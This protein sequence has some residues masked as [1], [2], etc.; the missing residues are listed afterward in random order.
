[1]PE[2]VQVNKWAR[3]GFTLLAGLF[4]ILAG[5]DWTTLFDKKTAALVGLAVLTIKG[6]IDVLAPAAGTPTAVVP[7]ATSTSF[8]THR[9]VDESSA[10]LQKAA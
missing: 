3:F 4:V 5:F 8:I 7:G 1:M 6:V 2:P 10:P 9:A